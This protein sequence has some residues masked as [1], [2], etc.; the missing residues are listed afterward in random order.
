MSSDVPSNVMSIAERLK[1]RRIDKLMDVLISD[2]VWQILDTEAQQRFFTNEEQRAFIIGA[3]WTIGYYGNEIE[4]G[5]QN[6]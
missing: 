3:A 5:L 2:E 6:E 1:Q 4:K